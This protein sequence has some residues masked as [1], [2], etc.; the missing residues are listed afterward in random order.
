[1]AYT[2]DMLNSQIGDGDR[3]LVSRIM[4]R[5]TMAKIFQLVGKDVSSFNFYGGASSYTAS[6]YNHTYYPSEER[7]SDLLEFLDGMNADYS[8]DGGILHIQFP[9]E[10]VSLSSLS[11]AIEY[12]WFAMIYDEFDYDEDEKDI[13]G[14]PI[15][16]TTKDSIKL[17]LRD[18]EGVP[19]K[20]MSAY[21]G[22]LKENELI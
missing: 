12:Q 14:E 19:L 6:G 4:S 20:F 10:I 21:F 22:I 16:E 18:Y 7:V 9:K 8:Y 11:E 2:I 13:D 17:I 1:M 3:Q 15:V 5:L